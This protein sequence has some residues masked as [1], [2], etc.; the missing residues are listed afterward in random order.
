MTSRR[1]VF[2][3]NNP[4]DNEEQHVV[5]W[6]DSDNCIYG[7]V[8]RE[9]GDSGTPHLQGFLVLPSPQRLSFLR[10]NLSPRAHYE[11]AQG[12][13][14]QASTYCKKDGDFEEFGEL[15]QEQGRR[16]DIELFEEWLGG[17]DHRPSER[18][19][20]R[21]FPRLFLRSRANLMDL[22]SHLSPPPVIQQGEWGANGR[23]WQVDLQEALEEDPDDRA[24]LWV[25]DPNGG[26][27]KSWVVRKLLS[28]R[29]DDVQV[30]SIGKGTDLAYAIDVSKTIF[31]F[32]IPRGGMEYFSYTVV[33]KLKD[34]VVFS[35]KYQSGTKI[36]PAPV[37]VVVFCN[38]EPDETKMTNTPPEM[39]RFKYI[40]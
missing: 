13:S 15:P 20:A 33:E 4:T 3:L 2:T 8:G 23:Q 36:L 35:G 5:D 29:P 21:A 28:E 16:T 27:G 9:T 37:H 30:L 22:V 39:S 38:E 18:E 12:T 34:Q 6:L 24:I 11:R 1:W 17:L 26:A 7:V 14:A 25:V 10:N 19:V 32:D 40:M 31:L